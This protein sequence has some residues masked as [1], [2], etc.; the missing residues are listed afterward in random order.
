MAAAGALV[1]LE[2][3]PVQVTEAHAVS[4]IKAEDVEEDPCHKRDI[5]A[6]CL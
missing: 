4:T 1:L 5:Q 2:V 3:L 6:R